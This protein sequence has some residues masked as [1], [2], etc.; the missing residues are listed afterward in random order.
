MP[1]LL[2]RGKGSQSHG[3]SDLL[4]LLGASLFG[5]RSVVLSLFLSLSYSLFRL[6]LHFVWKGQLVCNL[7]AGS[8]LCFSF[9]L[10]Q[11]SFCTLF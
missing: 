8:W 3:D 11:S 6:A 7:G 2:E 5:R 9:R 4:P 10:L 1:A